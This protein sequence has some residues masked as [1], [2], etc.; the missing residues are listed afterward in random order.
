MARTSSSPDPEY[1]AI[2]EGEYVLAIGL[3]R[4]SAEG[5]TETL[6]RTEAH[7]QVASQ[8]E[9]RYY[10]NQWTDLRRRVRK[11]ERAVA[12]LF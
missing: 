8:R 9:A 7:I 1:W 4:R 2:P 6:G 10:F 12:K 3:F 5:K 11:L